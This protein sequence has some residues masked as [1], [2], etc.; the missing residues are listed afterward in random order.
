MKFHVVNS[1]DNSITLPAAGCCDLIDSHVE[2]Y[3]DS[4]PAANCDVFVY[5]CQ[6]G[7]SPAV[8]NCIAVNNTCLMVTYVTRVY[9][10]PAVI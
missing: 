9:P 1:I 2:L 10:T 6:Q 3:V 8:T 7:E 4:L 5:S